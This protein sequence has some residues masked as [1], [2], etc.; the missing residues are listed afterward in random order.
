MCAC[1]AA[2]W[3]LLAVA[4]ESPGSEVLHNIQGQWHHPQE[5]CENASATITVEGDR[6]RFDW[7]WEDG[8]KTQLEVERV[9]RV[10]DGQI[11][12]TAIETAGDE[13]KDLPGH[14]FRYTLD[15]DRLTIESLSGT[16][17]PQLVLRCALS[18]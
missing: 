7:V 4:G 1:T 17:A 14:R 10:L 2:L 18:V 12:T 3:P 11:L 6:I 16:F 15:G 13:Q 5:R 9:D 8:A